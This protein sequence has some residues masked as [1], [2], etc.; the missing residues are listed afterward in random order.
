MVQRLFAP[1][2]DRDLEDQQQA[3]LDREEDRQIEEVRARLDRIKE[4]LAGIDDRRAQ[5]S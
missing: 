4:K 1:K 2:A 5:R 3:W